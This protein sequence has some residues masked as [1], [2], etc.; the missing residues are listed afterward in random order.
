MAL[1]MGQ[2]DMSLSSCNVGERV[3][4]GY[5][6]VIFRQSVGH[7]CAMPWRSLHNLHVAF[8]KGTSGTLD[9]GLLHGL[10]Q[11]QTTETLSTPGVKAQLLL[12]SV[13]VASCS[14]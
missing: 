8:H 14:H 13:G 3:E 10:P 4:K 5:V 2:G 12:P 1:F 7:C 6:H 9:L 11:H